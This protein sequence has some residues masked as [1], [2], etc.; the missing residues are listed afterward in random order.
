MIGYEDDWMSG[1]VREIGVRLGLRD[2]DWTWE[3]LNLYLTNAGYRKRNAYSLACFLNAGL[4]HVNG[5]THAHYYPPTYLGICL[6]L[7]YCL[8]AS[9]PR[10]VALLFTAAYQFPFLF[11]DLYHVHVLDGKTPH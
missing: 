11:R 1:D 8:I 7:A 5:Y 3:Y 2:P 4:S 9:L 6:S 10:S